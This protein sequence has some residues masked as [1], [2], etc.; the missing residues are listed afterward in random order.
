MADRVEQ[1]EAAEGTPPRVPLARLSPA[2]LEAL[3]RAALDPTDGLAGEGPP[4]S[5]HDLNP[6][7]ALPI[8]GLQRA[9]VLVALIERPEGLTAALSAARAGRPRPR[10]PCSR[11]RCMRLS[12]EARVEM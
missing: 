8:D 3:A 11:A 1:P 6:E 5:D 12:S 4:A 10:L 7:I 9:A 2:A